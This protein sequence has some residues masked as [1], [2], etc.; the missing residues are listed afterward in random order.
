MKSGGSKRLD[1]RLGRRNS[2]SGKGV[3][4]EYHFE[5][6]GVWTLWGLRVKRASHFVASDELLLL[7]KVPIAAQSPH[8]DCQGDELLAPFMAAA[9]TLLPD[10]SSRVCQPCHRF[11]FIFHA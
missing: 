1:E 2:S 8:C 4:H 3:R 11:V 5:E 10:S 7:L 9:Y 6:Q